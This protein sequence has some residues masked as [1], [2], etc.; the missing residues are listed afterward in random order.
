MFNI[1]VTQILSVFVERQRSRNAVEQD[2]YPSGFILWKRFGVVVEL[3]SVEDETLVRETPGVFVLPYEVDEGVL[4]NARFP[5]PDT[6]HH[7]R[8]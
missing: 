2:T 5:S 7:T 1:Y 3:S 6:K 4:V 8:A